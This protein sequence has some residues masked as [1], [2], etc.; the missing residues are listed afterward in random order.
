[1]PEIIAEDVVHDGWGR[2][3]L[4]RL[5]LPSGEEITREIE[6]HGAA[7][8]VL[9]YDPARRV[10]TLVSQLRPPLLYAE[11]LTE[12][13]EAPAGRVEDSDPEADA[14]REAVEEVGLKLG[15]LDHV[16]TAWSQ[17]GVST[18]RVGLYLAS[19]GDADRVGEGGGLAEEGEAVRIVEMPL[20][21]L[22]R[23]TDRG[24]LVD[25]KTA[26]LVMALR[27]RRPELF[28]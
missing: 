1:M 26:L 28:G 4:A 9:P 3:L 16:V 27:L 7:V 25:M 8:A 11:G 6:D 23:M 19:Y 13:L 22:G 12:I 21:E 17:P 5:R 15:R 2:F 18:E 20:A 14:R 24:E 10:A